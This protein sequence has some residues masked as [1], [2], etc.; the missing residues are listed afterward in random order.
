MSLLPTHAFTI[1]SLNYASHFLSK[2]TRKIVRRTAKKRQGATSGPLLAEESA[3]VWPDPASST[4]QKPRRSKVEG[5]PRG[6]NSAP[7]SLLPHP[8]HQFQ[9]WD[10]THLYHTHHFY[11][12][13]SFVHVIS[14]VHRVQKTLQKHDYL[15]CRCISAHQLSNFA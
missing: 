1:R 3:A 2:E 6:L 7:L 15:W 13:A 9:V 12:Y 5:G 4:A 10:P 14:T 11:S 8:G